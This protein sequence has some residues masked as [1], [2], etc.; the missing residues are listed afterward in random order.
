MISE[1]EINNFRSFSQCIVKDCRRI[2]L[3]VGDNG[4]GKT[5]FLE[6][7]FLAA[8]PSPEIALRARTWRGFEGG[9]IQG[10]EEEVSHSLWADLFHNFQTN[11]K[12]YVALR[13]LP[14]TYTRSV[15]ISYNERGW[16]VSSSDMQQSQLEALVHGRSPI[17]FTWKAPNGFKHSSSP[18]VFEGQMRIPGGPPSLIESTFFAAN[19]TYSA[20][21]IANRFSLL[22]RTFKEREFINLFGQ[23]FKN[24][25]DLSV[26]VSA[27]TP[28]LFA[29]VENIKEKVPISLASG[30]MNKLAA[31]LLA[32]SF[33]PG[34]VVFVDELE[35]GFYYKR[36]P[37]VWDSISSLARNYNVQLFVTTHSAE[38]L[39]AA[40]E[41]AK[42]NPDEF[43]LLRTVMVN[44]LTRIRRISGQ[45]LAAA[46]QED[47]EFR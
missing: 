46:Q 36:F 17:T 42:E 33:Q 12:A 35:S 26:E 21:E 13:G 16:M 24:I 37:Q 7:A 39:A 10:T 22:S 15:T 9:R 18:F 32:F 11:K 19:H 8:G 34:G 27:G 44:G 3:I 25:L 31:I 6:A 4:S 1:I 47:I 28:M 38:C 20:N 5:A 43:C 40:A 14:K 41:L 30:G 45:K 29:K 2:N 23:H